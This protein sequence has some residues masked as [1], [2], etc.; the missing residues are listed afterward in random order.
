MDI[1]FNCYLKN[2]YNTHYRKLQLIL[3]LRNMS[4]SPPCIDYVVIHP[5]LSTPGPLTE[6]QREFLN[7]YSTTIFIYN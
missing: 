1:K 3:K 6:E 4:Y 7:N 2:I 5:V